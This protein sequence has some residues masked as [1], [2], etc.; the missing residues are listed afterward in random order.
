MLSKSDKTKQFIIEKSAPLFN[1][2][3]YA[4]TTMADILEV[5]GLTKG[6]V[7]GNFQ[8]K[9]DIA[10]EAFEYALNRVREQ[11]RFKIKQETTAV[12]RLR[13]ILHFYHNY[14]VTPVVEGG[15]PILNTAIDTDYT[16]PFLKERALKGLK[17]MLASLRQIIE[18]GIEAGEF[19]DSLNPA[20]E[21][22][23]IFATIEGGIMM[24][25]LQGS[26]VIL[27]RLLD[28]ISAQIEQRYIKQ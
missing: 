19:K 11:L 7:Y 28:N 1:K 12:G 23:L 27:N 25:K 5:T 13:A 24:S 4:A 18:L 20:H 26:P 10:V 9:D 8:S 6:G 21:A 2:K 17:E 15:C 16:V 22:E 14:S 3:G